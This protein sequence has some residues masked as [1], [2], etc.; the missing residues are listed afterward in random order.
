MLMTFSQNILVGH[1]FL[2]IFSIFSYF[3]SYTMKLFFPCVGLLILPILLLCFTA[4]LSA[5]TQGFETPFRIVAFPE[6][7]LSDWYANEVRSTS[8][9]VFRLASGGMQGTAA[10]AVQP[11]TTYTGQLWVRL[12]PKGRTSPVVTFW[13]KTLRNGTGSRAALVHSSWSAS[14][15][16]PY[17]ERTPVGQQG[18]FANV[19]QDFRKFEL[20]IPQQFAS[21]EEVYLRLEVGPGTGAGSV[22]RWVMDDFALEDR[23]V[24]TVAPTLHMV[25][26]YDEKELWL[27][28]S[29]PI[30]PVFVLLPPAYRLG[31]DTPVEVRALNDS[32]VVLKMQVA[33]QE[34]KDYTLL[35][36]QLPDFSG[37]FLRDTLVT[38]RFTDPT[39]FAYKSLVLNEL[40]PAPRMDQDL[41]FVE[42]VEL[43]NPLTKELRLGGLSFSTSTSTSVL[44]EY[45]M[46][47]GDFLLL[48]PAA[49]ASQFQGYGKV[50]PLASWPTLSNAGTVLSLQT[51]DGQLIDRLEYR[52]GSWGGAEFAN[53]GYSL[54]LPDP[55][56][57]CEG[58]A[59]LMPSSDPQ[60]GTPGRQ[61]AR[62]SPTKEPVPLGL[63]LAFFRNPREVE[64]L[65]NQ[66]IFPLGNSVPFSFSPFLAVDS[67]WVSSSGSRVSLSLAL[68]AQPSRVYALRAV[69]LR[70]CV[71]S[72]AS[73]EAQ[74][75]LTETPLPGELILNELLVEPRTGDPKFVELHNTSDSKFLSLTS[76]ALGNLNEAGQPSQLRQI[77]VEGTML[78]PKG[79]LALTDEVNRLRLSY[80]K[81]SG[82]NFLE[83]SSLPSFPISGGTVLLV[84]STGEVV[85]KLVYSADWHHPLLRSTKGVSLERI[86]SSAPVGLAPNWHSAASSEEHA[87]PGR[88]NSTVL[89]D[90]VDAGLLQVEPLVF[91]PEG[92][93][94]PTFTTIRY[95]LD[96]V[97][98]VGSFRIYG[99]GGQLVQVL[100]ENQLLGRQ[101]LYAWTGTDDSGLRVRP[102]YYVL[103]VQLFDLSGRVRLIKKTIVIAAAL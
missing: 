5:Q 23:V 20:V 103:V 38:V 95:S 22:A 76:W 19:T 67:S 47:P 83:L 43:V 24:D 26:G 14:L 57:R 16:G 85:E 59:F 82:G 3:L 34:E 72:T 9:R 61:N 13:A 89:G 69:G 41:P 88:Q 73:V 90:E 39:A 37:N 81:S 101:G 98:W 74:L 71:G 64:L 58:S 28:F 1:T 66:P 10:L 49:Q 18:Q 56:Y 70:R 25:R 102:G 87:T 52:S 68:P 29:E 8:S 91:D 63:E 84:S 4:R 75:V 54:E 80:P 53:G 79:F 94:G 55:L 31:G 12:S 92:S 6:S 96:E 2:S 7:F 62:F 45:W 33:L 27:T 35:V 93:S 32:T 36:Q 60:R 65:F 86:S 21:M 99:T 48:C 15:T 42:Y 40:M 100:G 97:G 11:L 77:G 50:L 30:D 78:A 17:L 44:P 46:A 51:A